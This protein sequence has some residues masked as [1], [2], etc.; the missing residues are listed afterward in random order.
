M[1]SA[2]VMKVG[3]GFMGVSISRFLK[4]GSTWTID[5][6]LGVI[7]I[8]QSSYATNRDGQYSSYIIMLQCYFEAI[9]I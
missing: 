5:K 9:T 4:E 7:S 6:Q 2:L 3:V 8:I 1:Q